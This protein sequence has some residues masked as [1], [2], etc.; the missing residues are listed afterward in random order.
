[1]LLKTKLCH[2]L[3]EIMLLNAKLCYSKLNYATHWQIMLFNTN[4]KAYCSL[5]DVRKR[6]F[7]WTPISFKGMRARCAFWS[8]SCY[9]ISSNLGSRGIECT[10]EFVV[11]FGEMLKSRQIFMSIFPRFFGKG[12]GWPKR[13]LESSRSGLRIPSTRSPCPR[14]LSQAT[15]S[16]VVEPINCCGAGHWQKHWAY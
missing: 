2:L 11:K 13:Y 3:L 14:S 4:L 6:P 5:P 9:H 10:E 8:Y 1:M 7:N 16:T 15:Q 12:W